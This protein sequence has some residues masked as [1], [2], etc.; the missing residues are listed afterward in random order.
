LRR[1]WP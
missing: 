1:R